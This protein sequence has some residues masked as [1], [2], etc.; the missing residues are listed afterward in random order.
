M[1]ESPRPHPFAPCPFV[2]S[3]LMMKNMARVERVHGRPLVHALLGMALALAVLL[4]MTLGPAMGP[5]TRA[6][7]GIDKH[8]CAC[9]MVPGR[10]GCLECEVRE[11]ARVREHAP[12]PYPVLRTRCNGD[13][14]APGYAAL[15]PSLPETHGVLLPRS[16]RVLA[17]LERRAAALSRDMAEPMTPPPRRGL[18]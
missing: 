8:L 15:P 16:P 4:P 5:V 2:F 3:G 12:R 9:G 13:E 14:A 11:R 18:A 17:K 10:C 6:L 1:D 7:G